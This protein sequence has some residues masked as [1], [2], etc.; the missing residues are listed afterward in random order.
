MTFGSQRSEVRIQLQHQRIYRLC[1][2]FTLVELSAFWAFH[3]GGM[4]GTMC[5]ASVRFI[6]FDMDLLAFAAM[7]SIDA[8]DDENWVA[9][10]PPS[11]F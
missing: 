2:E 1:R 6:S 5:D 8:A 9:P 10:E 3:S 4:N 7:G 11:R